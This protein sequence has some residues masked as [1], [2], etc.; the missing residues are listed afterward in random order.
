LWIRLVVLALAGALA[1]ATLLAG[2]PPTLP[3]ELKGDDEEW[4][5]I[6][7]SRVLVRRELSRGAVV[8]ALG[9]E[10]DLMEHRGLV[11]A[12]KSPGCVGIDDPAGDE[13][14]TL[15]GSLRAEFGRHMGTEVDRILAGLTPDKLLDALTKAAKTDEPTSFLM[16]E[17]RVEV[18]FA[19]YH[20][21]QVRI[22]KATEEKS[23]RREKGDHLVVM[24]CTKQVYVRLTLRNPPRARL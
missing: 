6:E 11:E 13:V 10:M 21:W 14:K 16:E 9:S 20:Y 24:P 4:S 23:L 19:T 8:V 7:S 18:G 5:A 15:R 3:A 17:F 22:P 2:S 1:V 12:L